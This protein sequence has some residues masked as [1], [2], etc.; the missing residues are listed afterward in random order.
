VFE[1]E[2]R[3]VNFA[4]CDYLF[5]IQNASRLTNMDALDLKQESPAA[6]E[7]VLVHFS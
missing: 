1:A 7:N 5:T 6:C 2:L 3:D 4:C